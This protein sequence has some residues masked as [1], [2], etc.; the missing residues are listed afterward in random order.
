MQPIREGDYQKHRL[1][2]PLIPSSQ[3]A[4][5]ANIRRVMIE[6]LGFMTMNA[7]QDPCRVVSSS[8]QRLEEGQL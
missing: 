8:N 5:Q 7:R 3:W 6:L 4:R 2:L 1:I